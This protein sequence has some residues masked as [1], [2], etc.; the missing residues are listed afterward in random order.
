LITEATG[1]GTDTIQ[2]NLGSYNLGL[3]SNVENLTYSGATGFTGLGDSANNVITGAAGADSLTGNAGDDTL[4]GLGGAD[5]LS[6]GN[7]NDRLVGGLGNDTLSGG[8]GND[9]FV[10]DTA[11]GAGNVDSILDFNKIAQSDKILL[12]DDIF[13]RLPGTAAGK[14]LAAGQYKLITS[15]T[16]FAAGDADD[17]IIYNTNTDKLYYDA[18]GKG[19][20]AAVQIALIPLAG[21]AHPVAG[22]FLLIA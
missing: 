2:T 22:D 15:G 14:P 4:A 13:T 10:F 20:V 11:I 5:S 9:Q 1:G 6:G 12:D 7:G 8:L 19:G 18:D 16:G 17:R 3:V 21:T